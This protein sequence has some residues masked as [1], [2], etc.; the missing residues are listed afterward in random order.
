MSRKVVKLNFQELVLRKQVELKKQLTQKELA[1][2]LGMSPPTVGKWM[3]G[4]V[5]QVDLDLLGRCL[6]YFNCTVADIFDVEIVEQ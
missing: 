6:E 2:E 5:E 3:R 4:E 1:E